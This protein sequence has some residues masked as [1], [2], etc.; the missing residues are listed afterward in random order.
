MPI[1]ADRERAYEAKFAKDQEMSFKFLAHRNRL[2]ALWA[3][4][5]MGWPARVLPVMC[6][7]SLNSKVPG[8]TTLICWTA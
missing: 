4:D 6:A 1:F 8:M 5:R 7:T 2:L 3:A